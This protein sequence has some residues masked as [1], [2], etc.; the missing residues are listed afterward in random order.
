[1]SNTIDERVVQMRFDNQQFEQNVQTSLGTLGRL[2]QALN[3]DNTS[4]PLDRINEAIKNNNNNFSGFGSAIDSVSSKFSALEVVAITAIANIA[5]SITNKLKNAISGVTVRPLMDGF[6]EYE[7]QMDSVQTIMANTGKGVNEVNASLDTMNAYADKTIYNFQEMAA[8]L[9]RFTA[10][11]TE[12]ETSQQAIMGISNLAAVSGSNSQKASVAMYQLSQAIAA[13]SLKLQDWNSVVNAGMGGKVFQDALQRTAQHMLDANVQVAD[14]SGKMI[15]YKDAIGLTEGSIKD[16]I[17]TEGSFRESL[18]NGWITTDVLTETLR[19]FQLNVETTEDYEKTVKELVDSGYTKEQAKQIADMAKTAMDAATKVKTFSQLIDT[20][21]EALGSGWTKTWQIIFGDF[22]EAKELWTGVSKVLNG[23][24][25]KTSDARN[26]MLQTWKDLGGRTELIEAISNAFSGIQNVLW[27]IKEAFEDVFKPLTGETLFNATKKLREFA[28]SIHLSDD[29]ANNLY[30]AFHGVFSFFD[31]IKNALGSLLKL[32]GPLFEVFKAF[33]EIFLDIAS[34]IG[35]G[36]SAL[37][38]GASKTDVLSSAVDFLSNALLTFASVVR[39]AWSSIKSFY[40]SIK[41]S[42]LTPGLT[43]A[44]NIVKKLGDA[45]GSLRSSAVNAIKSIKDSLEGSGFIGT[46]KTVWSTVK[47]IAGTIFT[48]LSKGVKQLLGAFGGANG[49]ALTSL[50]NVL[51]VGGVGVVIKHLL[52]FADV[53]KNLK[54]SFEG[55]GKIAKIFGDLKDTLKAFQTDIK[56]AALI[57]IAIAVGILAVSLLVLSSIDPEKMNTGLTGLTAALSELIGALA[58]VNKVNANFKNMLTNATGMILIAIAVSILAGAIKKLSDLNL[59]EI[60]KGLVGVGILLKMISQFLNG[61]YFDNKGVVSSALGII[62]VAAAIRILASSVAYLGDLDIGTLAKGLIAIGALLF[63]LSA[64]TRIASGAKGMMSTGLSLIF[65][66]ASMKIFAS[67]MKDFGSMNWEE[68][69]KGLVAMGGALLELGIALRLIPKGSFGKGQGVILVAKSMLMIAEVLDQLGDMSWDQIFKAITAMGLALLELTVPLNLLPKSAIGKAVSL[70]ITASSL[71]IVANI[72]Q[73]FGDM[74]WDQIGKGLAAMGGALLEM[75]VALTLL[76]SGLGGAAALLVLAAALAII[77]PILI[78]LGNLEWDQI[79][80]GLLALAGALMVF[81]VAGMLLGS[82]ALGLVAFGVAIISVSA[83]FAAFGLSLLLISKSVMA[84]AAALELVPNAISALVMLLDGLIQQIVPKLEEL[85]EAILQTFVKMLPVISATILAVIQNVLIVITSAA[86][87]VLSSILSLVLR[88]IMVLTVYGPMI[89]QSVINLFISLVGVIAQNIPTIVGSIVNVFVSILQAIIDNAPT[90]ISKIVELLVSVLQSIRD[91]IPQIVTVVAEII[92]AFVNAVADNIPKIIDAAFNLIISFIEGLADAIEGNTERL[93]SAVSRLIHA[94][95]TAAVSFLK[96]TVGT[97]IQSGGEIIAGLMSGIQEHGPEI[98]S[99]IGTI[100]GNAISYVA[101]HLPEWLVKGAELAGKLAEGIANNAPKILEKIKE[102]LGKAA[103]HVKSE[104]PKW[105]KAGKDL[106]AGFIKGI[107]QKIKEVPGKLK[108]LGKTAIDAL[109][110]KL[111]SHSPSKV[112]EEIGKDTGQGYINGVDSTGEGVAKSTEGL[113]EKA[114]SG[115]LGALSGLADKFSSMFSDTKDTVESGSSELAS[116]GASS[117]D[118]FASGVESGMDRVS[119]AASSGIT[120]AL[121]AISS[122]SSKW[123][124][125]GK[126]LVDSLARGVKS[127]SSKVRSN[128]KDAAKKGADGA[129]STKGKWTDVGEALSDGLA[130]GVRNHSSK[131]KDAARDAA[132]AAYK[133]AK[134]KLGVKSPSR[135]FARLGKFVD[136]GLA[137]GILDNAE[138]V[139]SGAKSMANRLIKTAEKALNPVADLMSSDMVT[140]P[141]I[142]PVMDLSDIQNGS[143]RLYSMMS[144]MDRYS[145]HGN[146]DLA[147]ST[148]SSVESE[149]KTSRD[150]DNDILSTLID[151]LK[152]LQEQNNAHRGNTYIIDGITYDDGSNVATAINMLV[153]AARVGGRA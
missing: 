29:A 65:I 86:P 54:D 77:T 83:G 34:E 66:A 135:V 22:E 71:L 7:V 74:S 70:V 41:E 126:K 8:N 89:L 15:S 101:S 5:N 27:P 133:A 49:S 152:A 36:L 4:K 81:G 13:G 88:V 119:E 2:K 48:S 3:F 53:I 111:D 31:G 24:I 62:L 125:N 61:T 6:K 51:T 23:F 90:I 108:E 145:L 73:Q 17:A 132:E 37:S 118:E 20:T 91:A 103:N 30:D 97:F 137:K 130:K 150:R 100:L 105:L 50:L 107:G 120:A 127:G 21:K 79:G 84:L 12:L 72:L 46:L 122:T 39:T 95:I 110:E 144:D 94:I 45:L 140:D 57:K 115:L 149:R 68:I 104:L 129:K 98:L 35:S 112:F 117:M 141:V 138:T 52:S 82:A 55:A 19:Q 147:T 67:A 25:D 114:K 109:K 134:A 75:S 42:F 43:N 59:T 14:A 78:A 151:G 124:S 56:A 33:F 1:M 44:W 28:E 16:M 47:Q 40:S 96:S 136:L 80:K 11:G 10:A 93:V 116:A 64:F 87:M 102:G 131:I 63:E 38:E 139:E 128:A 121:N 106:V 69:K 58:L 113:G 143:N 142:K 85:V 92:V 60:A 146:I 99:K 153:R 32:T 9:G 123:Q 148:A 18:K 76:Q 26:S